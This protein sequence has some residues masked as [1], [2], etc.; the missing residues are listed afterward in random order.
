MAG[1][2]TAATPTI[3]LA[4][5]NTCVALPD[6]LSYVDGALVACGFGTVY[7]ALNRVQVSGQDRVLITGMGPVGMAAGLLAK[8]MGATRSSAWIFRR[9]GWTFRR[10]RGTI[11]HTVRADAPDALAQIQGAH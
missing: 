6:A 5:E 9:R 3:M 1:S 11:D 4:E 8:K 10:E 7:E 2:A